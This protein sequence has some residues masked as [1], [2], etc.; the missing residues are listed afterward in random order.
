MPV[1]PFS[2]GWEDWP[3]EETTAFE[4]I[5]EII[6]EEERRKEFMKSVQKR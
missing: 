4:L 3:L 1:L 2:G 5:E 6:K